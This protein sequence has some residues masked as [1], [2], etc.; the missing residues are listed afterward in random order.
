MAL[1]LW[2]HS[3]NVNEMD[4]IVQKTKINTTEAF[5]I[6][7]QEFTI[8]FSVRVDQQMIYMKTYLKSPYVASESLY[9]IPSK[10]Q[11]HN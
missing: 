1:V 2:I 4:K 8:H 7:L 11:K 10:Q 3:H 6:D 5:D 9:S